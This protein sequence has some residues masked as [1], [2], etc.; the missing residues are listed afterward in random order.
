MTLEL[1]VV[2]PIGLQNIGWRY[3][4]VYVVILVIESV[5][6]YGWFLETK[7]MSLEE[8]AVLFDGEE[9]DIRADV[10]QKVDV[11]VIEDEVPKALEGEEGN[12]IN[13]VD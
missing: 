7:G 8:I 10:N 4:I 1:R 3:Y 6:A 2:N 11:V 9:A 12:R 5:I 13:R